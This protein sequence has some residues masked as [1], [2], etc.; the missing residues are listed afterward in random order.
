MS[1][2]SPLDDISSLVQATKWM[3]IV[4]NAYKSDKVDRKQTSSLAKKAHRKLER[5]IPKPY[6]KEHKET[7]VDLCISLSTVD[8]AEGHF[9]KFYLES[10]EEE[11]ENIKIT[12]EEMKYE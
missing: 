6:E 9:E 11:L 3:L 8:R 2:I 10:L 5:Y 7:V 1:T 4:L 12:L